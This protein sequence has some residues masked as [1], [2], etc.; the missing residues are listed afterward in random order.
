MM[1]A[2]CKRSKRSSAYRLE[3]FSRLRGV[4]RPRGPFSALR[5]ACAL[6]RLNSGSQL[7]PRWR[8]M[9]SNF[10]YRGRRPASGRSLRAQRVETDAAK[11]EFGSDSCL[12]SPPWGGSGGLGGGLCFPF[13]TPGNGQQEGRLAPIGRLLRR[14]V[15]R[16]GCFP[17]QAAFQGGHEIDD[18]WRGRDLPGFNGEPL[19]LGFE[20]SW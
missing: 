3:S 9:D 10:R 1:I 20:A 4:L 5:R 6:K 16:T 19:H 18:G 15:L 8:G 12:F 11:R 14:G 17:R 13:P 2:N 7:T